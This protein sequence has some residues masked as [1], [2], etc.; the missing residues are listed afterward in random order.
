MTAPVPEEVLKLNEEYKDLF[1]AQLPPGLP[2]RRP[3]DH[4]ID[5]PDKYRIPAPRLDRL[6]PSEDVEL[7][8]QLA[9]LKAHGYIREVTSPF[10]SGI[11][12]V[13]KASAWSWIIGPS[14]S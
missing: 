9:N 8:K 1:P 5:F 10:G 6:A 12:F 7:Q 14:T 11:L 3:T 13:P 4:R 2:P